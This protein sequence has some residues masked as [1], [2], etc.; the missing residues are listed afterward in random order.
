M[1][2][3]EAAH[4]RHL[5]A[6][7]ERTRRLDFHR[8]RVLGAVEGKNFRQG[9]LP[10]QRLAACEHDSVAEPAAAGG[11]QHRVGKLLGRFVDKI[12]SERRIT[13]VPCK[14]AVAPGTPQIATMQPEV[15]RVRQ[16]VYME[17]E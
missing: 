1:R 13:L 16:Q 9:R 14:L 2:D 15:C 8:T 6:R 17:R 11:T 10:E 4:L 5:I 3:V 7:D 12:L